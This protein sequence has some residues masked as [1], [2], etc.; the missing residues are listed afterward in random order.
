MS[1]WPRVVHRQAAGSRLSY[2]FRHNLIKSPHCY[3]RDAIGNWPHGTHDT[4]TV[5]C[6]ASCTAW[7]TSKRLDVPCIS[8]DLL[9]SVRWWVICYLEIMRRMHLHK[10]D[11][12][13][14]RCMVDLHDGVLT[15]WI[16]LSIVIDVRTRIIRLLDLPT[17]GPWQN[18][19][20]MRRIHTTDKLSLQ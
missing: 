8:A 18:N 2:L 14:E 9:W 4:H 13:W 17:I 7:T 16:E 3:W 15:P 19:V 5:A 1:S 10:F 11:L 12:G 20:F 6:E